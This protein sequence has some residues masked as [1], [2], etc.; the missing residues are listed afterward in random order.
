MDE[1]TVLERLRLPSGTIIALDEDQFA[2]R[3]QRVTKVKGKAPKGLTLVECK[4]TLEFKVGETL[5][6]QDL[7]KVNY[8]QCLNKDGETFT[9]AFLAEKGIEKPVDTLDNAGEGEGGKTDGD[10]DDGN[11]PKVVDPLDNKGEF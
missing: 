3:E 9:D 7:P 6:V 10:A 8:H 2:R 11:T 1:V 5:Y 4:E